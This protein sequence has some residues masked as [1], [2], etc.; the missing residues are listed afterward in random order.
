MQTQLQLKLKIMMCPQPYE[1]VCTRST[2]FLAIAISGGQRRRATSSAYGHMKY[3]CQRNP[4]TTSQGCSALSA[5]A[6]RLVNTKGSKTHTHTHT[7][8]KIKRDRERVGRKN[9]QEHGECKQV[10]NARC[11]SSGQSHRASGGQVDGSFGL[12]HRHSDSLE[13]CVCVC[14]AHIQHSIWVGTACLQS[15]WICAPPPGSSPGNV[16]YN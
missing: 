6:A 1:G 12:R 14:A 7:E 15:D 13:M 4:T 16:S 9:Q 10:G 8:W 3:A 2:P 5:R 11:H